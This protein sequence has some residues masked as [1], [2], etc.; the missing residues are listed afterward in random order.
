MNR[1]KFLQALGVGAVATQV[2]PL[3]KFVTPAPVR[4]V[5]GEYA[6]YASFSDLAIAKAI[7]EHVQFAA[8]ELG[9]RAGQSID[10]MYYQEFAV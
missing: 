2:V 4:A 6:D 10:Q 5:I 8:M 9:K 1:R 3:M 7:D